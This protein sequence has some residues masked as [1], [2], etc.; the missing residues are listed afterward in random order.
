MA[1]S[2]KF[3]SKCYHPT[4]L[5]VKITIGLLT[6]KSTTE[7]KLLGVFSAHA[8]SIL[9]ARGAVVQVSQALTVNHAEYTFNPAQ[10]F[11]YR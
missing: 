8:W 4:G 11:I 7:K 10:I 3:K 2:L 6:L 5:V 9:G 1:F